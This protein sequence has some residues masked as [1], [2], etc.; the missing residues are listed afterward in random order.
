MTKKVETPFAVTL[1]FKIWL[2]PFKMEQTTDTKGHY[3]FLSPIPA[4]KSW[5]QTYVSPKCAGVV[6]IYVS[7]TTNCIG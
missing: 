7:V 1:G 5:L 2:C 3:S 4:Q 6:F